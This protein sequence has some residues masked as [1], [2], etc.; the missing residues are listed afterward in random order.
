MALQSTNRVRVAKAREASFNTLPSVPT[1]AEQRF[2]SSTLALNPQTTV[3][4]EIRSDRQVTDLILT[5][6]QAGGDMGG[7]VSFRAIDPDLEEVY[8]NYWAVKPTITVIVADT[9]ISSV[10]TDTITVA[11]GGA[12]FLD[13]H[14]TLLDGFETEENNG[15]KKVVSSTATSIVYATSTFTAEANAIPI[16][17]S[18]RAVGYEAD[19]G[20]I[21]AVTAGGAALVSTGVSFT[22]LGLVA[23]EWIK[24]GGLSATNRFA[25]AA[26]NGWARVKRVTAT[27]LYLENLPSG[28]VADTGALKGI[29]IFF[30]DRLVNGTTLIT[31]TFERQ[32]LDHS[33]VTY[34]YITGQGLDQVTLTAASQ[35]VVTYSKTYVGSDGYTTNTRLTPVVD[36]AAPQE[37]VMNSSSNVGRIGFDGSKISGPNFVTSA[38]FT[39]NNNLR[40]QN[41]VGSIGAVGLGQGEFNVTGTLQTYFGDSSVL[42][43]VMNNTLTSFDIRLGRAEGNNERFVFDFPSIKLSNGS[44]SISGKNA[45]VDLSAAFQA[46]MDASLGYTGYV[47]RFWF[48][49]AGS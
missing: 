4:S 36:V 22:T 16:G 44:P 7:E 28:W 13:G 45:D 31:S 3:S 42:E 5:G 9:E 17:A 46:L 21:Q 25:T 38:A 39:I 49:P 15:L 20:E 41:A 33:P 34:E 29:Q 40:R 18:V 10:T 6:V 2:T 48:T 32:Y 43:K 35:A 19:A 11:S 24:I 47:G 14:L 1:F 23:G 27:R 12:A 30:G 37:A 26:N 8:Q